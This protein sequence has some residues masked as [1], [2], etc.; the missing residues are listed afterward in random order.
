MSFCQQQSNSHVQKISY[1]LPTQGSLEGKLMRNRSFALS[2]IN[3]WKGSPSYRSDIK[4]W[5]TDTTTSSTASRSVYHL[6]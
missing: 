1:Q 2:T 4:S 3:N 5:D 6:K